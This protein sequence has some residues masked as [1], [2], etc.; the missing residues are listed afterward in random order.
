MLTSKTT[1]LLIFDIHIWRYILSRA[2][3]HK[4]ISRG[5][6]D[7]FATAGGFFMKK[8]SRRRLLS[9]KQAIDSLFGIK[10]IMYIMVLILVIFFVPGSCLS[11]SVDIGDIRL[12]IPNEVKFS[13]QESQIDPS[14]KAISIRIS[15]LWPLV[16]K[17]SRDVLT[18]SKRKDAS[19]LDFWCKA[20]SGALANL[21][22][23][24]L[25]YS[26][27]YSVFP[28]LG[29]GATD[30]YVGLNGPLFFSAPLVLLVEESNFLDV[31]GKDRGRHLTFLR[32]LTSSVTVE[33]RFLES[34]LEIDRVESLIY[35]L[36]KQLTIWAGPRKLGAECN[37][38]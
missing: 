18:V 14:D 3:Q 6:M 16:K 2:G 27:P 23:R 31:S 33:S 26:G 25:R 37:I 12:N 8:N 32:A 30:I 19:S 21:S 28:S 9:V 24:P 11:K 5:L 17:K 36:E 4:S 34:T 22:Q 38:K 10:Y 35:Y 29:P 7:V 13:I 15:S 20:H 1:A